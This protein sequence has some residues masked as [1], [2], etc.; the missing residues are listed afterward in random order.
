MRSVG[1]AS[2]E[3]TKRGWALVV[4]VVGKENP[5]HSWLDAWEM[6]RCICVI[7]TQGDVCRSP[8]R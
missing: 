8:R 4:Y 1:T 2:S 6:S 3:A 7:K 5:H